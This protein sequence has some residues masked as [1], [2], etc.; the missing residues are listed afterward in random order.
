M[1]E[2]KRRTL[3]DLLGNSV[4]RYSE[5]PALS[6]V[7][8]RPITYK[9]LGEQAETLSRILHKRGITAGDRVAILSENNPNWGISFFAITTI[10][11]VAVPILPDFHLNEVQHI[12]RHSGSKAIFISQKQFNKLEEFNSESLATVFLIEDFSII[13][14]ETTL[15]KLR[16]ILKDGASEYNKL[17]EAA[18]KMVGLMMSEVQEND[19]AVINYTSGTTGHSK[20]VML[21]HKNL[22]FDA[23]ATLKIQP[24]K[25]TDR[26]LSILP[27][28]HSYEGTIGFLIPM[29][30]GAC[31]YYLDKPP[32]AKVLL[33]AMQTV[34]PT[35]MLTVPL[36]MEKLYKVKI[37]PKF[38]H[39]LLMRSLFGIPLLRRFFHRMAAR[40]VYNQFGGAL[41]FYGIGG[42]LLSPE[43]ELFLRE[44]K[45]P[46][47][48]GYGLTE[49]SPLI[50]GSS[51]DKTRYR[52]T[53][54]VL[55]GVEV[56]IEN[57]DPKT[58][59]G[60][61]IVRGD[62]VMIGYYK[63]P[64]RT[65]KVLSPDGWFKTGDL[66]ILDKNGYL[67][68]KGRLKNVIVGPSGE[69]IYPEQI[70]SLINRVDYVLESLVYLSQKLLI[71]KV[72]L[73]Y[74]ELDR[75]FQGKKLT[76]T[77]I[78]SIISDKLENLRQSINSNISAYSRI[79]KMVEQPEPFEK[80]PTKKIKRYLYI[81]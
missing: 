16:N 62:N 30:C 80:T 58:G 32:V 66:G 73:N 26:L 35:M 64:E 76:E 7:N 27:L 1:A 19:L 43:V 72:H 18:L 10:G 57:P 22:V 56:K 53:G 46:Y 24:I 40:K 70:E 20:G 4:T 5:R 37:L 55:P 47:A 79:H 29:L 48:I 3:K 14:P 25:H 36:I 33:P 15:E 77:Q 23:L 50:A 78:S 31:V 21:S 45:F 38:T 41:H 67:Y 60:E 71:A 12:L 49:T 51:P 9:E 28:S 42:A 34:K 11:A 59:E 6:M 2:L 8:S 52:S 81:H 75:E 68:I 17:K 63:D 61:I 39:S 74:E 13:P 44:G 54:I 69:N 65:A